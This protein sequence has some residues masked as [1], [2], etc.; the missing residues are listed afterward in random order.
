M[1][2]RSLIFLALPLLLAGCTKNTGSTHADFL[3]NPLY[4]LQYGNDLS[5]TL[6]D[7]IIAQDPILQTEG[8]EEHIQDQIA[9]AKILIQDGK[10]LRDQGYWG[11]VLS[12]P[13][14]AS[15]LALY[16]ND[17]LYFS[18]DF[19]VDPSPDLHVY[20]APLVD[21]RQTNGP[22]STWIDLGVLKSPYAQQVYSVPHQDKPEL[23]R[24]LVIWDDE[25]ERMHAFAQ[26]SRHQD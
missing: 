2:T 20:L 6:T 15:G 25:F 12:I 19:Y 17:R 1:K 18:P 7:L 23:L 26:L 5:N 21:P 24:S 13:E 8:T 22:D 3:D 4:A 9:K 16:L 14:E 11:P 10:E